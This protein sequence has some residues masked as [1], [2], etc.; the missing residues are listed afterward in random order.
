MNYY[1]IT[2]TSRGLGKSI[3]KKLQVD[4]NHVIGISRKIDTKLLDISKKDNSRIDYIE[5]DLDNVNIIEK[6]IIKI[7]SIIDL[8]KAEKICLVN[9]AGVI[10]PIKTIENCSIDEITTSFNVNTVAPIV[11]TSKFI[12]KLKFIDIE[13]RV[14]NISSGAGKKPYHGWSCYC[15]TK[16]AVDMFTRC[17]AVE[18]EKANYPTKI[19]SFAPGIIDTGMQKKIRESSIENFDQ[20]ERFKNFK[21]NDLLLTAD[22]VADKVISLLEADEFIQGGIIDIND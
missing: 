2:G 11:I 4:G 9:N 16:A 15:S 10:D 22:F 3:A 17:V 5:F 12:E 19:L 21:E 14:I 13:K 1:I 18:Q 6:L 7:F 20:L 8:E